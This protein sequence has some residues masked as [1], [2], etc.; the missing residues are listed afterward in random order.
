MSSNPTSYQI[1]MASTLQTSKSAATVIFCAEV[2]PR[3]RDRIVA[4][5]DYITYKCH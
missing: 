3:L 5:C 1:S 2:G 4:F